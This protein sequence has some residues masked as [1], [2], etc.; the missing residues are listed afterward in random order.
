MID[1]PH[2][3][4]RLCVHAARPSKRAPLPLPLDR[5]RVRVVKSRLEV[6][7]SD[8]RTLVRVTAPPA[9]GLP[10]G[11]IATVPA[12]LWGPRS[13]RRGAAVR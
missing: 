2:R 1:L 8:T 5:V 6:A 4:P 3:L 10:G 9:E 7:A 13:A 11:V 12:D